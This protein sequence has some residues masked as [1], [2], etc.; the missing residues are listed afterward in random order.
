M[1]IHT[2]TTLLS[3]LV[4]GLAVPAGLAGQDAPP[5]HA[6]AE[7][8]A[9]RRTE[10]QG[11]MRQLWSEHVTWTRH[12]IVSVAADLPDRQAAT[13]R[14]MRNQEEI[15]DAI[16]PYYGD[17]A[18]GRLTTLLKEHIAIAGELLTATKAGQD[19]ATKTAQEKWKANAD[20][21]AGFLSQANPQHWKLD[22]VRAMLNRHLDI[23]AREAK[24]RLQ[25]DWEADIAAYDDAHEQ[26]MEMAD[27]LSEGIIHQFPRKFDRVASR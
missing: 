3:L 10:F 5:A 9:T 17:E 1:R 26:A 22:Q 24:A 16:K 8:S 14:L 20:S 25:G 13:E 15:G 12:V 4:S 27:A 6:A 23:T 7:R 2:R 11:A 21:I 18:G 19:E